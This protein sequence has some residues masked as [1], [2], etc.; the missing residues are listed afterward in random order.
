M[1]RIISIVILVFF[2][3]ILLVLVTAG[4]SKLF[5]ALMPLNAHMGNEGV[6]IN[7]GIDVRIPTSK[8]ILGGGF[9]YSV[10]NTNAE[11]VKNMSTFSLPNGWNYYGEIAFILSKSSK[12]VS[13]PIYSYTYS[14]P[15]TV[16]YTTEQYLGGGVTEKTHVTG[17]EYDVTAHDTGE[18]THEQRTK[19]SALRFG[20]SGGNRVRDF[21]TALNK[22]NTNLPLLKPNLDPTSINYAYG[23]LYGTALQ[24]RVYAGYELFT[25]I[26]PEGWKKPIFVVYSFDVLYLIHEQM[27]EFVY[28]LSDSYFIT[29]KTYETL[30]PNSLGWQGGVELRIGSMFSKLGIGYEPGTGG[31]HSQIGVGIGF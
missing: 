13:I 20:I 30:K 10:Y 5:V 16:N 2:I 7:P 18:R 14:N 11:L 24:H 23:G 21:S 3:Q 9:D 22:L 17:T 26:E 8:I 25:I 27:G 12:N 4:N 19:I 28:D 29:D 1:K 15:H 6:S 31:F